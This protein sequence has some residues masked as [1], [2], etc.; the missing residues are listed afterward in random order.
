MRSIYASLLVLSLLVLPADSFADGV[1]DLSGTWRLDLENSE[2]LREKARDSALAQSTNPR[3]QQRWERSETRERQTLEQAPFSLLT[4]TQEDGLVEIRHRD[5]RVRSI[6][7]DGRELE[8]EQAFGIQ[9]STASWQER[10]LV[11][12]N[13]TP[14]GSRTELWE[15]SEDRQHLFVTTDV[16]AGEPYGRLSFRRVY[17]LEPS[18]PEAPAEEA[19]AADSDDDA[20]D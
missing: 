16:D 3:A 20:I 17:D 7:T 9:R 11:I 18:A 10:R 2:T 12:E 14:R 5:G 19:P 13:E 4:L 15:L 1:P 6:Y 8:P